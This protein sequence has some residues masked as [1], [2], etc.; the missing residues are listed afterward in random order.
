VREV[1]VPC[2][3]LDAAVAA[4]AQLGFAIELVLPADDP[5]VVVLSRDGARLRLVRGDAGDVRVDEPLRVTLAVPP[6]RPAL[7]VTRA[8]ADAWHAGRAGMA[9]RDLVPDRLGGWVVASHIRIA[10]GGPVADYVHF[11]DLRA[12][13]LYCRA[14][15][16]RLV[17]EDQGE[18]FV[19]AAG[20]CIVQPPQIR[21][22]VLAC[23]PGFEVIEVALPA[24]HATYAD[25]AIMLPN[26]VVDR[27]RRWAGQRFAWLRGAELDLAGAIGEGWAGRTVGVRARR[28][29]ATAAVVL[30]FVLE[31]E[32][33]LAAGDTRAALA[34]DDAFCLPPD[35]PYEVAGRGELLELELR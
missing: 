28:R 30:G 19:M 18:P 20:E 3:D 26:A 5:A 22:R 33:E 34:R 15:W 6:L 24:A 27:E 21:H 14:G 35:L 8:R 32:L 10:D 1:I 12:Q 31:G 9:Y 17:Y 25:R 4:F 23:S 16:V 7:V 2:R 13:I 11:H 29:H